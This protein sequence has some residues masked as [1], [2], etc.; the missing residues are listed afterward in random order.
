M[1]FEKTWRWFGEK[2]TVSLAE[3]KQI[4]IE[5]IVTALHHIPN[6][7][8]WPVEEIM[9]VKNMIESYG[10][11][12][13]VVESLP[14]SE[15]IKIKS[16]DRPRL[17]KNYQES[18]RNLGKCGIDTVCYNFMPVLDW[19]RTDLHF[20]LPSGGEVMY[21]DF[22][23]FVAFDAF[24]LKR[25]GAEND[26]PKE[27][28]EKARIKHQRMSTEEAESLAH[29]II[30]V[31]QGFIDGAVDGSTPDYKKAFLS[32]I[33]TYKNIDHGI[34]RQHLA[35]FL[36]DVVPVA[37]EAGV[38]MAIHP[39]DPPFSVLGLPR[40]ASTKDDFEWIISQ[41]DSIS[42]GI[43][44][45]TGSLSV[46][47][48]HLLVDMIKSVG[49]RIHFLHLRN[50]VL[51][52]DGCFHEYGHIH[53]CVDMYEVVKALLIEQ[54]RRMNE[55]RKDFRLPVRPDHG[56][57]MLDDY[58]RSANPGYPLIGRMKG[59]AELT[60]LEMGIERML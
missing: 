35:D 19:V 52:P 34:L 26:Y 60:G 28:V 49:H 32:F 15:G 22:P 24:I 44:F 47:S 31:T 29:N 6:G 12:W 3:L 1:A 5:G 36:N 21:F 27:I 14:V 38:R 9:R 17:I 7:E 59:L 33:D 45:C 11:R 13:S 51:L 50:N 58:N 16:S 43:T 30:V 4:G 41:H 23:T 37:E 18:L 42:N 20:K 39:D 57:K 8:V 46:K 40:I 10:M 48:S 2:D 56:I 54:K 53:G 55:G 25:P